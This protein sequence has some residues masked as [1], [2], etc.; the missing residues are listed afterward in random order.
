MI[1]LYVS[2]PKNAAI[3]Q[4]KEANQIM[5]QRMILFRWPVGDELGQASAVWLLRQEA[6]TCF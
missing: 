6:N 1:S 4:F 5:M 3:F 2:N